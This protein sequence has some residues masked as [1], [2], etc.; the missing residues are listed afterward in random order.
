MATWNERFV[1]EL[2]VLATYAEIDRAVTPTAPVVMR[3]PFMKFES[4]ESTVAPTWVLPN[5]PLLA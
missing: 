5:V 2:S 4:P 3:E 1:L